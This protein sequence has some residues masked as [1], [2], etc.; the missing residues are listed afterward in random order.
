[1]QLTADHLG[2]LVLLLLAS[3]LVGV[4]CFEYWKIKDHKLAVLSWIWGGLVSIPWIVCSLSKNP[5][6]FVVVLIIVVL[7]LGFF[8]YSKVHRK[9]TR[10]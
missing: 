1:M 3:I 5:V 7:G 10:S 8:R 4:G 2:C 6:E 9:G